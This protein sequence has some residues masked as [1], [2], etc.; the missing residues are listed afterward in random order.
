LWVD[1]QDYVIQGFTLD[2]DTL[3]GVGRIPEDEAVI[4]VPK[5]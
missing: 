2:A 3:A 4:R 1:G 5:S